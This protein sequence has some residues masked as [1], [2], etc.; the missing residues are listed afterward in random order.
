MSEHRI[1]FQL[2]PRS[3]LGKLVIRRLIGRGP[4]TEVYHAFNSATQRDVAVKIY[5][6]NLPKTA[7]LSVCFQREIQHIVALKHPNIIRMFEFSA[8]NDVFYLVMELFEGGTLRDFISTNPTGLDREEMMRLFTQIGSAVAYAHDQGI[9][10]G[11][12]KP[13]NVL[14]DS[15]RRPV[16]T[17]FTIHC[18]A[19]TQSP[20][21]PAA[22]LAPEEFAGHC[23]SPQCDVY[24]LGVLLYE[25]ITGDVPFK[26]ETR[27]VLM[28]QHLRAAPPPPSQISLGLDPRIDQVVLKALSKDPQDRYASAREMLADLQ[29]NEIT[30]QYETLALERET[31]TVVRKRQSD[32]ARFRLS[33]LD[34][35]DATTIPSAIPFDVPAAPHI[36][37]WKWM[38]IV[39]IVVVVLAVILA[40]VLS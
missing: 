22:Y 17:D 35:E 12:I 38:G 18:L 11:S 24:G 30:T 13:D 26:G 36:S 20:P 8:E 7:A 19:Q 40:L 23:E 16:L 2:S 10:H 33:R 15:T 29:Q 32:I 28:D 3:K 9:T 1:P 25:M 27:D 5:Y 6:P 4:R 31:A 37:L 14:L 34:D 21:T 39:V